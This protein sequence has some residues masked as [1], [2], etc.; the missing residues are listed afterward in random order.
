VREWR[1]LLCFG[2]VFGAWPSQAAYVGT[3]PLL[4]TPTNLGGQVLGSG[5]PGLQPIPI[6]TQDLSKVI[7]QPPRGAPP[8]TRRQFGAF[9]ASVGQQTFTDTDPAGLTVAFT[10]PRSSPDAASHALIVNPSPNASLQCPFTS[11]ISTTAA[12]KQVAGIGGERLHIC[13]VFLMVAGQEQVG[14]VEGTGTTCGTN[15]VALVGGTT[16]SVAAPA[17]GGFVVASDRITIPMQVT[18]DDLCL[19]K[20]AANNLSG[21]ITYGIFP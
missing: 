7:A 12:V 9:L 4:V 20:S 13:S 15:T 21:F 1:Y 18:G 16:A 19:V 17:N 5:N 10:A 14:I 6:L 8:D 11:A 3:P 2:I